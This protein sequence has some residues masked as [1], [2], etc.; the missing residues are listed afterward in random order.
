MVCE[1]FVVY[2]L[3][4]RARANNLGS[5]LTVMIQLLIEGKILVLI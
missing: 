4:H 3:I 2:A 5:S 1:C